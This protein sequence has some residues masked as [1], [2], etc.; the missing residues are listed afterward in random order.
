[1]G[2]WAL[3]NTQYIACNIRLAQVYFVSQSNKT[4]PFAEKGE[5]E[6]VDIEPRKRFDEG[7]CLPD[8]T[9]RPEVSRQGSAMPLQRG[10]EGKVVVQ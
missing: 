5:L 2:K 3:M 8:A 1:M 10:G 6:A 4:V 9:G 7:I